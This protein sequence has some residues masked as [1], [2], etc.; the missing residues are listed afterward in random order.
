VL[1]DKGK[2]WISLCAMFR[3]APLTAV[4]TYKLQQEGYGCG[5]FSDEDCKKKVICTTGLPQRVLS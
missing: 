3:A 5:M 2:L 4:L 1:G